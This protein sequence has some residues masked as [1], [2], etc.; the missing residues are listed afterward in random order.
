MKVLFVSSGNSKAFDI[1]PFIKVQGE[2]LREKQIDIE[3]FKITG[4][5]FSG[6]L[7]NVKLLK[8][9]LKSN[10]FDVIHAHF[11]LSAWVVVL[12]MPRVPVVLSLMGDDARGRVRKLVKNRVYINFFTFS[13][14]LIQPFVKKIISKSPNLE[15][16][17]WQKKKSY[18]LPNGVDV[19]KFCP[20]EQDFREELGLIKDKKYVLFLGNTQDP[21][22][23]FQL[24]NATREK[25]ALHG[26]EIVS[27][28]PIPHQQVFKYLNSV[29]VLVMCSLDEGS[30]NVVKEGMACNCKGV[31]TDVGDVRYLVNNT[32]GYAI[33]DFD[34]D[35]LTQ[36]ILEV[37]EMDTCKGRQRL[38]DLKLDLPTV[39]DKLKRIY[40]EAQA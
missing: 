16:F 26:I 28:Y 24:L 38:L 13:T 1:A 21:T 32:P 19:Q 12:A 14:L 3:Y 29:D 7:S 17:V 36:K 20:T 22:K 9:Q 15:K 37:M 30:P 34:A 31:F 6:Y 4:K 8:E 23:N 39:A 40:Q 5:G 18:L 27:P 33:T 25:L 10:E 35:D 11:T 2:S